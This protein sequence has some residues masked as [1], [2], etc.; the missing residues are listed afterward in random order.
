[1]VVTVDLLTT[2]IDVPSIR[3]LV[4]VR[5]VKSRILYEQMLGR[6]TRPC[7]FPDGTS[8]E[9]FRI[10][11]AVD[12]YDALEPYSAMRPVV[13]RPHVSFTQLVEELHEAP[14]GEHR[15]A[16]LEQLVAKLQRKKQGLRERHAELFEAAAGAPVDEVLETLKAGTPGEAAAWF[17]ARPQVAELLD[18]TTGRGGGSRLYI[19]EHADALQSL[20]R[21]YG[22]G[23]ERPEDYLEGFGR[24]VRESV[25]TLP[26][27]LVVTQR[28]REL[29]REALKSLK[30]AL[31]AA[32][33]TEP[34]LRAAWREVKN[35]DIAA[36]LIGF[37][38]Q[39]ALGEPLVPY[40][41][42]VERAVRR[43]LARQA[44]SPPQRQ[45]LQR[46]GRQLAEN[47]VLDRESFDSGAFQN[48]GGWKAL[49]KT[50][51]GQLEQVLGELVDHVWEDVA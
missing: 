39:Q 4:F 12:L 14:D 34:Q 17:A 38:R 20:S 35:E 43:V 2:G 23:R 42:R 15:R 33:Y 37:V 41:E 21:G 11:D 16:V 36:T 48:A 26:A 18:R 29:T 22:E 30:L 3:N 44:W 19:S 6:A 9:S 51:D 32:G 10:F 46:I 28:P 7:T 24:F 49:D 40:A 1:V 5:R 27:L 50:L 13:A 8:K 25:N 45:W 31:D 47:V